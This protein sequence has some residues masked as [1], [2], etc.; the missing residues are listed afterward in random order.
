M[1]IIFVPQHSR[2]SCI[3]LLFLHIPKCGGSSVEKTFLNCGC[4]IKLHDRLDN[5]GNKL[6]VNRLI[7]KCP[8]QHF[9]FEILNSMLDFNNFREIFCLVSNPYSRLASEYRYMSGRI[10]SNS[11]TYEID[12]WVEHVFAS[13]KQNHF[14]LYN[15]IR[16]QIEF[17]VPGKTRIFKLENGIQHMIQIVFKRLVEKHGL[18]QSDLS[19]KKVVISH[20]NSTKKILRD[21]LTE[22]ELELRRNP[23]ISSKIKDFYMEDFKAFY[24]YEL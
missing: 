5:S 18:S 24:S 15:H 20:D 9:H 23:R 21:G 17:I 3:P 16:P 7:Y 11:C 10:G 4:F 13:Y 19:V 14:L 2:Q 22:E 8:S 12:Q 1:P 6:L